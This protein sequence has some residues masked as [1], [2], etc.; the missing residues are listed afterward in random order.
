MT[1]RTVFALIGPT[2][3]RL[4]APGSAT[5]RLRALGEMYEALDA[6]SSAIESSTGFAE[7]AKIGVAVERAVLAAALRL[8]TTMDPEDSIPVV[9]AWLR[10]D[11]AAGPDPTG[12]A[13][14]DFVAWCEAVDAS[15]ADVEALVWAAV[16][17]GS[18]PTAPEVAEA[19]GNSGPTGSTSPG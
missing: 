12:A 9:R 18:S 6:R 19:R 8:A 1:P 7:M 16:R 2:T 4:R 5:Q 10:G 3:L 11:Y 13:V 15:V 14:D 17:T